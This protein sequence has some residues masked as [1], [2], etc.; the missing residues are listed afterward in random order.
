M[1]ITGFEDYSLLG[2]N[3]ANV[4]FGDLK[5]Y[6]SAPPSKQVARTP[7]GYFP[8]CSKETFCNPGCFPTQGSS[9]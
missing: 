2:R 3:I 1:T 8:F 9:S 6:K 7:I 5:Q 4:F